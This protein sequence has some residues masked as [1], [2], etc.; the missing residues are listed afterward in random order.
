MI[1]SVGKERHSR[2]LDPVLNVASE[3]PRELF[4][5]DRLMYVFNIT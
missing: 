2:G 3:A 4:F 1:I 5:F